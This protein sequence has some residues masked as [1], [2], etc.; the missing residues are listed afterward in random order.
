MKFFLH[1]HRFHDQ[2]VIC[3][4]ENQFPESLCIPEILYSID[5]EKNHKKK[6][7]EYFKNFPANTLVYQ[8]N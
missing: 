1:S 8:F 3:L 6:F 5:I 4:K 7:D 2:R